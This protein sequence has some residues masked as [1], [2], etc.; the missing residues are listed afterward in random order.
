[1][2]YLAAYGFINL[3]F[4]LESWASSDFNPSF[5]VKKWVGLAGFIATFVVM[6]RL[7]MLAMVAAFVVIGGI[8]FWLAK[9]QLALGSGDVWQSVW[10]SVVKTGLRRMDDKQDSQRNWKPNVLLFSGGTTHRPH[11]L[12]FSKELVGHRGIVTNFDLYENQEAKLL[13]PKR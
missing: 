1:M 3:S 5:K 10:S 13:F 4:F 7:D 12:E 11:L 9:K 2:F 6:F 8:Y